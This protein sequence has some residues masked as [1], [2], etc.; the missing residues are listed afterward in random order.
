MSYGFWLYQAVLDA[1]A[2][3]YADFRTWLGDCNIYDRTRWT[4]SSG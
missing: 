2:R 1:D 3:T 4:P